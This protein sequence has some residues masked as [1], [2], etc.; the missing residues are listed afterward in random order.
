MEPNPHPNL[1][2]FPTKRLAGAFILIAVVATLFFFLWAYKDILTDK[3]LLRDFITYAGPWGPL[4]IIV[5]I[6]GEVVV[7]PIPGGI[8]SVVS[9]F[10]F[11]PWLGSLYAYIGSVVGS[12]LA[13]LLADVFGQPLVEKLFHEKQIKKA[14]DYLHRFDKHLIVF[15]IFPIFPVDI[16][17]FL[18]GLTRLSFRRFAAIVAIGFIPHTLLLSFLGDYLFLAPYQIIALLGALAL[19]FVLIYFFFTLHKK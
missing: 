16:L 6:V 15:Y 19:L 8:I 11:G 7:A 4:L 3:V 17:S 5:I 10:L 9:G 13:F 1:H 2:P 12:C 14:T 18:L